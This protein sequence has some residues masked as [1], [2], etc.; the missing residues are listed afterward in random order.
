M[1]TDNF[2]AQ[3][4]P[5][6]LKRDPSETAKEIDK[7]DLKIRN[8]GANKHEVAGETFRT[9]EQAGEFVRKLRQIAK[10]YRSAVTGQYVTEQEAKAHPETTVAES[11]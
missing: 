9:Q 8:M 1:T 4:D 5:Y 6:K 11:A 3:E 7:L 2:N 10:H